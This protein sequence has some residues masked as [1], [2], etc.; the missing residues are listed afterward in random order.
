AVADLGRAGIDG[1]VRVIAVTST[2]TEGIIVA[3]DF[4]HGYDGPGGIVAVVIHAVAQFGRPGVDGTHRIITIANT[5]A[6]PV[7]VV[8][9]FVSRNLR[10]IGVETVVV[11]AVAEL[12]S[13]WISEGGIIVAVIL[14][15]TISIRVARNSGR[16]HSCRVIG[17]WSD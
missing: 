9:G 8:I 15:V 10:P 16:E 7:G 13:R 3:V 5:S 4:V 12:G 1:D 6:D 14:E 17:A 11:D 2:D